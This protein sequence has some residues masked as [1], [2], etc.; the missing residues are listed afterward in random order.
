MQDSVFAAEVN[1]HLFYEVIKWQLAK[2]R[3]GTASTKEVPAKSAAV[4]P[5]HRPKGVPVELVKVA[6]ER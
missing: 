5:K 6:V 1:R 3:Q 4:V 2:R